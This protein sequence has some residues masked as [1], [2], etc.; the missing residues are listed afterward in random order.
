MCRPSA[1]VLFLQKANLNVDHLPDRDYSFDILVRPY[2]PAFDSQGPRTASRGG[3]GDVVS[4]LIDSKLP[5]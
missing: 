3:P 2:A 4:K 5:F 1:D